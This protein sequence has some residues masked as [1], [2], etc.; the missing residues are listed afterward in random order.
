MSTSILRKVTLDDADQGRILIAIVF[1]KDGANE[2]WGDAAGLVGTDWERAVR[3]VTGEAMSHAL[4]GYALPLVR[5]LGEDPRKVLR[6]LGGPC[7]LSEGDQCLGAG[8]QCVPG[9][10]MPVCYEPPDVPETMVSIAAS[11]AA[12]MQ[13]GY[14]VVRVVGSEFVV[15]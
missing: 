13:E 10:K 3:P 1:S 14:H 9:P 7:R 4:H 5:E 8:P 11:I 2:G 12:A 15:R 6:R